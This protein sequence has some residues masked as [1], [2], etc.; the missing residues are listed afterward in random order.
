MGYLG[1]D[2]QFFEQIKIRLPAKR[3]SD[4]KGDGRYYPFGLTMSGLSDKAI[5]INYAENKYRF[6]GKELQHQ[7]FSDGSG[8]EEYDFGTR[9][10]DQQLGRYNAPD[11]LADKYFNWSTYHYVGDNPLK[12]IDPTG[13]KWDSASQHLVDQVIAMANSQVQAINMQISA[14]NSL[15]TDKNGKVHLTGD[16]KDQ[17]NELNYRAG[18]LNESISQM[19]DM[20]ENKEYT[21]SLSPQ[22]AGNYAEM[23]TPP[24]ND[25]KHIT[26]NYL[27]G[28]YGNELHEI[29]HGYQVMNGQIIFS[30]GQDGS[31]N[32]TLG[33]GVSSNLDLEVPAYQ[34]QYSYYGTLGGFQTPPAGTNQATLNTS[35]G[36]TGTDKQINTK[37]IITNHTQITT[38]FV[39]SIADGPIGKPLY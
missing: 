20:G 5:K 15:A 18:K 13:A 27:D 6:G 29:T 35:F 28:D 24:A 8:L 3:G 26:I 17:I 34:T 37:F 25:L 14:I 33:A 16:Q 23:P 31:V 21:F 9:L 1:G 10:F 7:E 4:E 19:Q 39:K 36:F 22:G 2:K 38:N 12:Y 32:T 30:L 11:P